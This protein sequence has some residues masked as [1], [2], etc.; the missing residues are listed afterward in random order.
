MCEGTERMF[1]LRR[2]EVTGRWSIINCA[3]RD[4]ALCTAA[5][6]TTQPPGEWGSGTSVSEGRRPGGLKLA[7]D[8]Y[9]ILRST[10]NGTLHPLLYM[11]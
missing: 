5:V 9:Q 7:T 6:G 11:L 3:V 8:S 1:G 2:K 4:I 10:G